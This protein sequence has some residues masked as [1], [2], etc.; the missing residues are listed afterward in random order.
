MSGPPTKAHLDIF[1]Y[2]AE[3]IALLPPDEREW[4]IIDQAL[5][6]EE[7]GWPR[8]DEVEKLLRLYVNNLLEC[9]KQCQC[10]CHHG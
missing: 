4:A 5:L 9:P 6:L 3:K 8:E 10:R 2:A 1:F 7:S